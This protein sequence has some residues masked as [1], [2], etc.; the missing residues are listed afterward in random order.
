MAGILHSPDV[1]ARIVGMGARPVGSTPEEVVAYAKE[2]TALWKG[3]IEKAK[4]TV[5]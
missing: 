1:S 3:V 4:I 2:T 5:E